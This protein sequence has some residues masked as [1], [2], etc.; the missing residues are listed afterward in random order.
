MRALLLASCGFGFASPGAA[1]SAANATT[2]TI[3]LP[4]FIAKPPAGGGGYGHC[5]GAARLWL[6]SYT[7]IKNGGA[8][9]ALLA[10]CYAID[11]N[12]SRVGGGE[13]APGAPS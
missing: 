10:R 2:G 9:E 12:R 1:R 11:I 6:K 7:A 3:L 5:T 4:R 13:T 8:R